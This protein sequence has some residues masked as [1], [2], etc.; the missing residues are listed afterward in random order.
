M[1]EPF[2][3]GETTGILGSVGRNR[4]YKRCAGG[5][6][7]TLLEMTTQDRAVRQTSIAV[8]ATTLRH[9]ERSA[10]FLTIGLAIA[11]KHIRHF[12][13]WAIHV[14]ELAEVLWWSG[15]W[16]RRQLAAGAARGD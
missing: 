7:V 11:A 16:A 4:S 3:A 8:M 5:A 12:E 9:R 10:M 13:T 14:P 1:L 15:A 2:E 6:A